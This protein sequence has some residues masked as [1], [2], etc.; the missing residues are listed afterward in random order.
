MK[1]LLVGSVYEIGIIGSYQGGMF[2]SNF[3]GDKHFDPKAAPFG[4]G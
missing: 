4:L 3:K 2:L 1:C